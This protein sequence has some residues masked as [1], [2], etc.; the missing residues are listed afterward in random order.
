MM[1]NLLKFKSRKSSGSFLFVHKRMGH[2]KDSSYLLIP[3]S[4]GAYLNS[5]NFVP[6]IAPNGN[7]KS[8]FDLN[9][10]GSLH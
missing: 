8:T 1:S 6:L 2:R 5:S 7:K 3:M 10:V 9:R 4:K